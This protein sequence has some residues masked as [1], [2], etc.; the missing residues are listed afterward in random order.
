MTTEQ[1]NKGVSNAVRI[2]TDKMERATK[3]AIR[4]AAKKGERVTTAALVD[5][6]LEEGLKKREKQLGL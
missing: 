4:E 5:E 6:I 1:A 2:K 3:V